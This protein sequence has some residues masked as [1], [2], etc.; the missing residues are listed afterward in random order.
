MTDKIEA[1]HRLFALRDQIEAAIDEVSTIMRKD[2]PYE[3]QNA[4]VY[5]IAHIKSALG[6]YGYSTYSTTFQSALE[7]LEEELYDDER[8]KEID[9]EII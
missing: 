5:W 3:Y 7:S 6:G 8:E 4:E 9:L 2:F 1:F